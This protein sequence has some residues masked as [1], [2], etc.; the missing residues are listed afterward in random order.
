[1]LVHMGLRPAVFGSR[2]LQILETFLEEDHELPYY[3]A[4]ITHG[5]VPFLADFLHGEIDRF[6]QRVVGGVNHLGFGEFSQHSVESFDCVGGVD[7]SSDFFRVLE[8]GGN[9]R[10]VFVP[11][12]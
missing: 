11:N 10:P 6:A 2:S 4:P 12:F 9:L 3:Y 7:E 1:M 5:Q 8:E